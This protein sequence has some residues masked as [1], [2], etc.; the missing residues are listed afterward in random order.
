MALKSKHK[1]DPTFNMSS[2]T[3]VIFLLLIFFMLTSTVVD[4][5]A[6]P[7]NLPK[8]KSNTYSNP[9]IKVAITDDLQYFF[10]GDKVSR[11]V[12]EPMLRNEIGKTET[13]T[14]S[15]YI[16]KS[17]PTEH[18]VEIAGIAT[19]LKAKVSIATTPDN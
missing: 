15:L 17:V 9:V 12:I 18:F 6:L 2:M 19:S 8:S 5:M 13:P 7:V 10:N 3:D 4:P 14:V 11:K 1:V 16:D